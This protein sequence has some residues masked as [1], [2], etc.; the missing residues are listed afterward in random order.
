MFSV[1]Y[2]IYYVL[3]HNIPVVFT[4]IFNIEKFYDTTMLGSM[5]LSLAYCLLLK[6]QLAMNK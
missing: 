6:Q 5:C 2:Q 4:V 1:T 3:T